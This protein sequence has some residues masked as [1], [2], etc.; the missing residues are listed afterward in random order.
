MRIKGRAP[1]QRKEPREP[2]VRAVAPHLRAE[3]LRAV[4]E[5]RVHVLREEER[6]EDRQSQN[7]KARTHHSPVRREG[8]FLRQN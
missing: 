4:D 7:R 5:P 6:S 2:P 8:G 3:L 1:S